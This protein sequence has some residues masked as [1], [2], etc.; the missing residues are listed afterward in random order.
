M[1]IKGGA[2]WQMEKQIRRLESKLLNYSTFMD[3]TNP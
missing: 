1:M 2:K 3:G